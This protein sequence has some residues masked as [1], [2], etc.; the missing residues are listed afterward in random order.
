MIDTGASI[1]ILADDM[2]TKNVEIINYSFDLLGIVGKEVSVKT[3][4]MVHAI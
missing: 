4:R 3:K 2:V 1:S